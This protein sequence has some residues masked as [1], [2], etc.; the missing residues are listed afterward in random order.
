MNYRASRFWILI[1]LVGF[2]AGPARRL[3]AGTTTYTSST[4]FEAAISGYTT[5]VENYGGLTDGMT[6]GAGQ[7]VDGLTYTAFTPGPLGDLLGGII[8]SGFNNFSGLSLGG[9]QNTGAQY[10]FGGDSVTVR[11]AT[12][13][14]AFGIFFNVNP[15]SGDYA[16]TTSVGTATTG[17]ASYDTSTFVFAGLVSTDYFTSATFFST[18][19]SLGSYNI[20]AIITA[21]LPEPSGLLLGALGLLVSSTA[22][23]A[24]RRLA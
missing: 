12:P 21:T 8:T 10:F 23:R 15:N 2:V 6:I 20:P 22:W 11:F 17:S 24:R 7:T 16:F 4:A 13:V 18:D 5:S 19:T 3:E 14:N 9:N 1:A